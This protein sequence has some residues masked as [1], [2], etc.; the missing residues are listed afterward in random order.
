M[1]L[2]KITLIANGKGWSESPR[3]SPSWGTNH[4]LMNRPVDMVFEIHDLRKKFSSEPSGAHHAR[5]ARRGARDNVPYMVR[6]ADEPVAEHIK[7]VYPWEEIFN[8]FGTDLIGSSFD[9]MMAYAIYSG[10]KHFDIYGFLM[11]RGREYDHQR[12][13]AHFWIGQ[14]MGRGLSFYWH[15]YQGIAFSD[16]MQTR[17]GLVYGLGVPQKKW[18][19]MPV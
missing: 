12:D 5:A 2:D 9:A 1:I 14:L 16:M 10:Y 8:F 4:I 7:R 13:S 17:D 18:P 19:Y 6:S 15:Q 11:K 3:D